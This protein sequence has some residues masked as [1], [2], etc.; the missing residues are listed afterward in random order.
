M[1]FYRYKVKDAHSEDSVNA[2][3]VNLFKTWFYTGDQTQPVHAFDDH[4][5]ELDGQVAETREA[6]E[7]GEGTDVWAD[8]PAVV[9]PVPEAPAPEAT[10]GKKGKKAD[11]VADAPAEEVAEEAP[12]EEAVAPSVSEELPTEDK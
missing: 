7:A 11:A 1:S 3:G 6:L 2:R 4:K 10:K 12:A 9:A 8:Q 5:A